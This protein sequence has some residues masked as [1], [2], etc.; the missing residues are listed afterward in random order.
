MPRSGRKRFISRSAREGKGRE[1]K[2]ALFR[3]GGGQGGIDKNDEGMAGKGRRRYSNWNGKW[4]DEE[5][6]HLFNSTLTTAG[7]VRVI[8][9]RVTPKCEHENF[10]V[11][12]IIWP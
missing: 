3:G 8:V 1:G 11:F 2:R 5:F 4:R 9:V 12:A 7:D 6:R 10:I